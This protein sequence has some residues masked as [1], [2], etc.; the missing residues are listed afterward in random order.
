ML[1]TDYA[2][3]EEK[4]RERISQGESAPLGS[5]HSNAQILQD[6]LEGKIDEKF[7]SVNMNDWREE[8]R[9]LEA[10]LETMSCAPFLAI[11]VRLEVDI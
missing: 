8:E 11:K 3:R 7:W 5:A 2:G 6:K 1:R 4:R 9:Q 10:G